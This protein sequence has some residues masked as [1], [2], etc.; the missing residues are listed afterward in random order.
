MENESQAEPVASVFVRTT[1][2]VLQANVFAPRAD[3]LQEVLTLSDSRKR[4][5]RRQINGRT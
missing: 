2:L 4:A 1:D 3:K 5:T